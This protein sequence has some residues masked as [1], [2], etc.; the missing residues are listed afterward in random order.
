MALRI[1]QETTA[2]LERYQRIPMIVEVT[3]VFAVIEKDGVWEL[4][5]QPLEYPWSKDY[6]EHEEDRL[7]SVARRVD[8]KDCAIFAAYEDDKRIGGAIVA[9]GEMYEAPKE[10]AVLIDL[11]VAPDRAR[12]GSGRALF[13]AAADWARASGCSDLYAETQN[14]NVPA[15]RFYEAQGCVISEVTD[16]SYAHAPDEIEIIW[17]LSLG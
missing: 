17:R 6:E 1:V 14:V 11:R 8:F 2:E 10:V 13:A 4:L 3:S 5:E 9:P 12:G 16:G 15:C 7:I